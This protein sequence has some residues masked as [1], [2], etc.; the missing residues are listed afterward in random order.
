MPLFPQITA[1]VLI[2]ECFFIHSHYCSWLLCFCKIISIKHLISCL[3]SHICVCP[4]STVFGY[5]PNFG[6]KLE[7]HHMLLITHESQI[8]YPTFKKKLNAYRYS[9]V[10]NIKIYFRPPMNSPTASVWQSIY[11]KKSMLR[12][13][14][15]KVRI[16]GH[17]SRKLRSTVVFPKEA[18]SALFSSFFACLNFLSFYPT[19]VD[20]SLLTISWSTLNPLSLN[21]T[22]SNLTFKPLWMHWPYLTPIIASS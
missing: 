3:Y 6:I 15:V 18:L 10:C 11:I 1:F 17:T 4:F 8:D 14:T 7:I 9:F 13:K 12:D 20:L 19:L 22:S 2:N 21:L 16:L 5:G